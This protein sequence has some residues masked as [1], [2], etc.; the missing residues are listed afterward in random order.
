KVWLNRRL[1]IPLLRGGVAAPIKYCNVTLNSARPGRSNASATR[2]LTSPAVPSPDYPR[3]PRAGGYLT[4]TGTPGIAS[5]NPG[6]IS[7]SPPGCVSHA[8]GVLGNKPGVSER[9]EPPL[10]SSTVQKPHPGRG[11]RNAS[12][13]GAA[14]QP[15][16]ISPTSLHRK[17]YT[18][19]AQS[20]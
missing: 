18:A 8:G 11:A 14:F 6:L 7:W 19:Q 9:S 16:P 2:S 10:D 17:V 15:I 3:T 1:D 5:L 20:P 12:R 4:G 13:A